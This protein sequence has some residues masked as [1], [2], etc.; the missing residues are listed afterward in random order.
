MLLL[1]RATA[2]A[3]VDNGTTVTITCTPKAGAT[4]PAAGFNIEV[5]VASFSAAGNGLPLCSDSKIASRQVQVVSKP[6]VTIT[7]TDAAADTAKQVCSNETA[8]SF[9]YI[10]SSGAAGLPLSITAGARTAANEPLTSIV[11]TGADPAVP[12]E[13]MGRPCGAVAGSHLME[14]GMLAADWLCHIQQFPQAASSQERT[15]AIDGGGPMHLAIYNPAA[16]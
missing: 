9:T 4:W 6:Q 5:T 1:L 10:V 3:G 16:L 2:E 14:R 7:A 12:G 13:L 8:V 15:L 11:C